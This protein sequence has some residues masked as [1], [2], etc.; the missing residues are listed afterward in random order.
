MFEPMPETQPAPVQPE[1]AQ[2]AEA[3]PDVAQTLNGVRQD[4]AQAVVSTND[5]DKAKELA[6]VIRSVA[7]AE[8]KA[9]ESEKVEEKDM[10][11]FASRAH[12]A[13]DVLRKVLSA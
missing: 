11:R 2:P 6:G 7:D 3:Q 8:S 10:S 12:A 1:L 13:N 9:V 5:P 4:L